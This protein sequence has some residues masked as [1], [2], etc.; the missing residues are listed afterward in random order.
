MLSK[1]SGIT[2]HVFI[3]YGNNIVLENKHKM[4]FNDSIG[5]K[6]LIRCDTTCCLFIYKVLSVIRFFKSLI[7]LKM[8]HSKFS[9]LKTPREGE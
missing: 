2:K 1:L 4:C 7:T 8:L 9:I 6:L 3:M 5:L